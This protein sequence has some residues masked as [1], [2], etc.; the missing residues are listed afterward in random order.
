LGV[1]SSPTLNA[2]LF[3]GLIR[4][5]VLKVNPMSSKLASLVL[6]HGPRSATAKIIL[7]CLADRAD[8][9]GVCFPSRRD[10]MERSGVSN[11]SITNH[12]R[13]LERDGWLQRKAR[14]NSSTIF[15]VN[16]S[17]L[18]ALAA[19]RQ[20]QRK[21]PKGFTPF[22]E[23]AQPAQP[24][25][26]KGDATSCHTD[27]TTWHT[28]ATKKHLNLSNNL[29]IKGKALVFS[30]KDFDRYLATSKPGETREMWLARMGDTQAPCAVSPSLGF[31]MSSG[32]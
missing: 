17:R 14:F 18:L 10:I 25:E 9:N 20:A 6:D 4:C 3:G 27:A 2:T 13:D 23:D 22:P 28:D 21:L 7:M 30:D 11:S 32:Q 31:A 24:I 16:V 15:R 1:A 12:L 19:D 26:N 5:R 29:P 8:A